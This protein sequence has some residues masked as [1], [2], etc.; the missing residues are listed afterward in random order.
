MPKC[1]RV[2]GSTL[3]LSNS[4]HSMP[5]VLNLYY[6]LDDSSGVSE[7]CPPDRINRFSV[8]LPPLFIFVDCW[9]PFFRVVLHLSI[10]KVVVLQ[11]LVSFIEAF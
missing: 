1:L 4:F 5:R 7:F 9:S 2:R 10:Y 11:A 6:S 3:A 8:L